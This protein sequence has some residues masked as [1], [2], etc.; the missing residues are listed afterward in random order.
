MIMAIQRHNDGPL[1]EGPLTES[2]F[3]RLA[4][5]LASP[6]SCYLNCTCRRHIHLSHTYTHTVRG[7]AHLTH[8]LT[9]PS[10]AIGFHQFTTDDCLIS[11][12]ISVNGRASYIRSAHTFTSVTL[13]GAWA[14]GRENA[15]DERITC[16][17]E[18]V[19]RHHSHTV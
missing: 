10:I 4:L 1:T 9:L 16:A 15:C 6:S 17:S 19:S 12:R 5:S 18:H 11:W 13:M 3:P 8:T 7:S 2:P 14:T